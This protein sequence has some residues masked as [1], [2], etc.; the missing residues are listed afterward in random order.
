MAMRDRAKAATEAGLYSWKVVQMIIGVC[1]VIWA[2]WTQFLGPGIQP[3]VRDFTGTT[4]VVQRLDEQVIPRID[5]IERHMPLP[6]VVVWN[7]A[8]AFQIEPCDHIHC[9]Y[10]LAGARTAYGDLCGKVVRSS[11]EVRLERSG[12]T[13]TTRYNSD[14]IPVRLTTLERDFTVPIL[15]TSAIPDG[16]HQWRATVEYESCPGVRE[17]QPRFTP[18]YPLHVDRAS[19]PPN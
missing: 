18:W 19:R 9:D 11:V 14:F 4:E 8:A 5:H 2:F 12:R 6:K 17:P 10:V 16:D 7:E 3:A 15:I 13:V 1:A